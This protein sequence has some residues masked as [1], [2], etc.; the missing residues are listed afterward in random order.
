MAH[1]AQVKRSAAILQAREEQQQQLERA[2]RHQREQR[3]LAAQLVQDMRSL[4]Q[5]LGAR[6]AEALEQQQGKLK[7]LTRRYQVRGMP[8]LLAVR[9][10]A[11][12]VSIT[13]AKFYLLCRHCLFAL[14]SRP[15]HATH[16]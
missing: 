12:A 10:M 3:Q 11:G 13:S 7:Q 1:A 8:R 6:K 4:Q 2:G 14:T 5:R 16:H 15:W 9:L